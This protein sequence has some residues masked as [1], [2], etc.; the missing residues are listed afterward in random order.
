MLNKTVCPSLIVCSFICAVTSCGGPGKS[1]TPSGPPMPAPAV[2]VARVQVRTIPLYGDFIG[3]T[4]AK[5]TVNIVPRVT[6]F[7]EKVYFTEG[8]PV[9]KGQA[10]FQIEQASYQA[11]LESANAKVAEDQASLIRYDRDVARLEPLVKEQAATQ[12]DL[13]TAVSGAAQYRA[14]IKGDQASIDTAQ[15]NLG[16]TLI[17][18]PI[19]GI[20]GKLG[21]TRGNLVSAGQSTA[22]ATISSFD[23]MYVYFSAPEVTYLAFRRS[24]GN[25]NKPPPISMELILADGRPF[26]HRGKLDFADRTVDSQTGTLTLRAVFPNPNALLRPGQFARVHFV[27]GERRDAVLVPKEAVTE[28]LNSRSVLTVD[29]ANK[30]HL[31]TIT[32]DG[33]FENSFIVHAGLSGGETIVVEGAQKVLPGSTVR[34]VGGPWTQER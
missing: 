23:P 10:L 4:D 28:N 21:V 6:G 24:H 7:L 17:S 12:Q 19:D 30:A 25:P 13:D 2:R 8:A 31:K 18:S 32:T 1:A 22:L 15:L 26:D 29:G 20:I 11:S 33:E 5:E 27:R 16:Y 9:H 14:A 34:P 3:Q